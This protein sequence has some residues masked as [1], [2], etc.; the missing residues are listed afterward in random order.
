MKKATRVF[1]KHRPAASIRT[2]HQQRLEEALPKRCFHNAS[3]AVK[4]DK[5]LVVI[6]GWLIGDYF[7]DNGTAIIPHYWVMNIVTREHFDP[8]PIVGGYTQS[9]DYVEDLEIFKYGSADNYIPS[10]LNLQTNGRLR[11]VGSNGQYIDIERV[12][13]KLLYKLAQLN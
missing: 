4:Q 7:G 12:D 3:I 5:N 6:S 2:V 8:T 13:V 9:Y 1:L 11:A 10:A